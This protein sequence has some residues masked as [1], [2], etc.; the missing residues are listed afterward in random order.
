[1]NKLGIL[2]IGGATLP[3]LM[4]AAV[5]LSDSGSFWRSASGDAV[6]VQPANTV[7]GKRND[8]LAELTQSYVARPDAPITD[9]MRNGR[10][11]A[12]IHAL[13]EVLEQQGVKWR[14]RTI[15]GLDAVTYDVS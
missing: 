14:V 12:P 3:L 6:V 8:Y 11:L 7:G 9:A 10:E 1:M 4:I 15:T 2:C 5:A 13:N